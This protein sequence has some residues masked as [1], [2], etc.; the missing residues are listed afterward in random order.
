MSGGD[1]R[2]LVSAATGPVTDLAS[3]SHGDWVLF[4]AKDSEGK[5]R[6]YRIPISGGEPQLIGDFSFNSK[7][8]GGRTYYN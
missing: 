1:W 3:A 5:M 7:S 2:F 8:C 6:L 4:D